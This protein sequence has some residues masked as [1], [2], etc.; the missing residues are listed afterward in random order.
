MSVERVRFARNIRE[1]DSEVLQEFQSTIIPRYG[2]CTSSPSASPSTGAEPA[3]ARLPPR[4]RAGALQERQAL[5]SAV[6]RGWK[7]R[8]KSMLPPLPLVTM[9][10]ARP[11]AWSPNASVSRAPACPKQPL[12][13]HPP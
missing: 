13:P 7:R 4:E 9:A 2:A 12:V 8:R 1:S 3:Q 11:V 6:T 10:A 5:R